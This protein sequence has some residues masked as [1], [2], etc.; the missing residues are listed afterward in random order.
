VVRATAV[1]FYSDPEGKFHATPNKHPQDAPEGEDGKLQC[2][3]F[4]SSSIA[5]QTDVPLLT[6]PGF[7]FHH[8]FSHCSSFFTRKILSS[9]LLLS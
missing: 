8:K 6:S 7:D 5:K 9:V 3:P 2:F 1:K 4:P